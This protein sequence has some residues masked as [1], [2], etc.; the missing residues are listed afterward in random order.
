MTTLHIYRAKSGQWAGKL[1]EDGEEVGRIAGCESAQDVESAALD[2]GIAF[3][4]VVH[5]DLEGAKSVLAVWI[6]KNSYDEVVRLLDQSE[7][8]TESPGSVCTLQVMDYVTGEWVQYSS[9]GRALYSMA[10]W[11]K[12]IRSELA[13]DGPVRLAVAAK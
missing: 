6:S 4:R 9:G 1:L 11:Y 10:H 5:D 3:D 13:W 12:L 2:T 7:V 8:L